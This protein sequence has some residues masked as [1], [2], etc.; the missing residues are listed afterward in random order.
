M[1]PI[2]GLNQNIVQNCAC[3]ASGRLYKWCCLQTFKDVVLPLR[4]LGSKSQII[5]QVTPFLF[6]DRQVLMTSLA[7]FQHVKRRQHQQQ[8]P[9]REQDSGS[10]TY[11]LRSHLHPGT[12]PRVHIWINLHYSETLL[13]M[14]SGKWLVLTCNGG[15][16]IQLEVRTTTMNLKYWSCG[17]L[18]LNWGNLNNVHHT[19][20]TSFI[21]KH[22]SRMKATKATK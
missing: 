6:F 21:K 13:I 12:C 16:Y 19:T 8:Q 1:N 20:I 5:L 9:E 17:S 11:R 15:L 22:R 7:G 4:K 14:S 2:P 18:E 3:M 10:S